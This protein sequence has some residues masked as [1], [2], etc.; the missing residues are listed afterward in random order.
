MK[1]VLLLLGLL[2]AVSAAGVVFAGVRVIV[3]Q[4]IGA[5]PEGVTAVVAGLPGARIIDSPDGMCFR[6]MGEVTL[7]CRGVMAGG[8]GSETT[9][10]LRLPYFKPLYD[11]TVPSYLR[12]F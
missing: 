10:L 8:I 9:I 11:L 6:E 7:I 3:I 1:I 2:I 12:D 5:L 4:P